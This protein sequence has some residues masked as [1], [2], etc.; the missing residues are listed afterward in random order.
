M[1]NKTI[2]IRQQMC[3]NN[4]TGAIKDKNCIVVET[5]KIHKL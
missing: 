1:R 2:A 4:K 3:R 5:N